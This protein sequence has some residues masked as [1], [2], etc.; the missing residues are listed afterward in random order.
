MINVGSFGRTSVGG[1]FSHS[2]LGKRIENASLNIPLD[3]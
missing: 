1:I 2:E 3:S